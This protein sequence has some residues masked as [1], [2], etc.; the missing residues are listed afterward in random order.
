LVISDA[1]STRLTG[2]R[3]DTIE[4]RTAARRAV[5]VRAHR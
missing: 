5:P 4:W 3:D 1:A 2:E